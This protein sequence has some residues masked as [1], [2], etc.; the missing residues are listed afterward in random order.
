[1]KRLEGH[2]ILYDAA[3]PMCN[4]Y[5][6]GFQ[7][8]GMLSENGRLAYHQ[9]PDT[10]ACLV[11]QDR[12]VNEIALVNTTS[13]K[14]YYG[15][16]SLLQ[17]IVHSFPVLGPLSQNHLFRKIADK[18]YK[19][20]SFNRRLII[21]AEKKEMQNPVLN[22][23]FH[24]RYR[25]AYLVFTCLIAAFVLHRYS[26][27][28]HAILPPSGFGR[29][30]LVCAGQLVWQGVAVRFIDRKK[31]WDYL[32]NLMTIS[33]AGSLLLGGVM[34]F[35]NLFSVQNAFFYLV[36]FAVTVGL[37]LLE[38]VRRTRILEL[39]WKLSA[40]WVL[41]RLVILFLLIFLNYVK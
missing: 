23:S 13:G 34:M 11:N 30:L 24:Q 25:M 37:M 31:A 40:T 12:S 8:A 14:V 36:V 22:P 4:L 15:V 38:H 10:F 26:L 2:V 20:I 41:Y 16:E 7:K 29:E 28:L 17:I 32:G 6:K 9:M 35:G 19:F 18:L 3:C 33:L 5:T 21:P 1:M 39:N 27:R